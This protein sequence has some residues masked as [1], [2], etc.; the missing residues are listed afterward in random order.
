[1]LLRAFLF[2]AFLALPSI[3]AA[4]PDVR[5]PTANWGVDFADAQCF[6]S[7]DY[8]TAEAPLR[9]VLKAPPM[10]NVIQVAVLRKGPWLRPAQLDGWV[11]IGEG[12][13]SRASILT[14]AQ[15]ET[16]VRVY[17]MNM[18]AA[19]FA[20]VREARTL[21]MEAGDLDERFSLSDMAPLMKVVDDCVADLRRV[22]HISDTQAGATSPL[23]S[24]ARANIARL[25]KSEDYPGVA[26]QKDQ[27]G[28]VKFVLL[29]DE[30]GRVADC[31]VIETSGV[32]VLDSQ[33]CATMKV[34]ARF[35]PARSADGKPA[36]DAVT[37]RIIWKIQ[38]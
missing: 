25:I 28:I 13:R 14:Y 11:R 30:T 4:V 6:A 36:K 15:K 29:I 34:R 12:P 16:G 31:T 1:M 32:A 3:A 2:F 37:S 9:L 33:V 7:R 26:L 10:G 27:T 5:A 17:T 35:E 21:S 18:P 19:D 23:A 38:S 24:R 8:G 20:L 22:F